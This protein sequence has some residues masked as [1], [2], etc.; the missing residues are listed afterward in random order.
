[1]ISQCFKFIF[2]LLFPVFSMFSAEKAIKPYA[3]SDEQCL[4]VARYLW[5]T[6]D[7]ADDAE[8]QK[9]KDFLSC[10][11][12]A[13]QKVKGF[14]S[15]IDKNT[16]SAVAFL[17]LMPSMKAGEL[18]ISVV[19]LEDNVFLIGK[20]LSQSSMVVF[21]TY[22]RDAFRVMCHNYLPEYFEDKAGFFNPKFNEG[23]QKARR[24]Q[25]Q[26]PGNLYFNYKQEPVIN[27]ALS[28]KE[29]IECLQEMPFGKALYVFNYVTQPKSPS[30]EGRL[31][32]I[33]DDTTCLAK[34]PV[35][36]SVDSLEYYWTYEDCEKFTDKQ[37]FILDQ[38][39]VGS[40]RAERS[41]DTGHLFVVTDDTVA[42]MKV[43]KDEKNCENN[44]IDDF[45]LDNQ[46]F[47]NARIRV[48]ITPSTGL[49]RARNGLLYWVPHVIVMIAPDL[50]QSQMEGF[51]Q[52]C[53]GVLMSGIGSLVF[54]EC[55]YPIVDSY[56]SDVY[57]LSEWFGKDNHTKRRVGLD[58]AWISF[59]HSGCNLIAQK[60]LSLQAMPWKIAGGALY[61]VRAL[62]ACRDLKRMERAANADP[63]KRRN[64]SGAYFKL[65]DL[66]E[67]PKFVEQK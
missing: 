63:F 37:R 30:S 23:V 25:L 44:A 53:A 15:T 27:K 10:D 49:E 57:K 31:E 40:N 18:F 65:K 56:N 12:N 3:P 60:F 55:V 64:K 47:N 52:G 39:V 66:F 2:V 4:R 32:F 35:P 33:V 29:M 21:A 34:C 19:E 38:V 22:N 42:E 67:G 59:L 62:L 14:L 45:V 1:M 51:W 58:F 26:F 6:K 43:K 36:M 9:R 5:L 13:V 61:V 41:Y 8:R 11:H 28:K 46:K 48:D 17:N 54:G 7:K 24:E 16:D 50:V 20:L